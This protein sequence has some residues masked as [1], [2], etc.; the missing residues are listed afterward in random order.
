MAKMSREAG[1]N[2]QGLRSSIAFSVEVFRVPGNRTQERPQAAVN[3]PVVTNSARGT[4]CDGSRCCR[5]REFPPPQAFLD[6]AHCQYRHLRLVDDRRAHQT[7]EG[8]YVGQRK[9]AAL[10]IIGRQ[11]AVAGCISQRIHPFANQPG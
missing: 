2:G 5:R 6:R 8:A 3:D 1:F 9:R 7:A 11:A 4:S 10:G